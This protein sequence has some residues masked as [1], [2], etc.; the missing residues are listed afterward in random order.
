[1]QAAE[2]YI[3]IDASGFSVKVESIEYRL[4]FY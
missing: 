2:L 4:E 3:F 1:M